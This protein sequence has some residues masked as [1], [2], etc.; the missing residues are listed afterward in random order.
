METFKIIR[1]INLNIDYT[2]THY[3]YTGLC[4]VTSVNKARLGEVGIVL[5]LLAECLLLPI[6]AYKT[7]D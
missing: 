7:T 3:T 5:N 4:L 2:H 1:F 6:G